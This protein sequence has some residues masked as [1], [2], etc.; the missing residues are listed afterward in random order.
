MFNIFTPRS[1]II[2][3][4]EKG[5]NVALVQSLPIKIISSKINDGTLYEETRKHTAQLLN[6]KY[7]SFKNRI[8]IHLNLY[9]FCKAKTGYQIRDYKSKKLGYKGFITG[10]FYLRAE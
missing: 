3:F 4:P 9:Y 8:L 5:Q 2:Y 6:G 7:F 10:P 1:I